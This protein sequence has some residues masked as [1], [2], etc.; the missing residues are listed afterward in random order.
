MSDLIP[1]GTYRGRVAVDEN[2]V[3]IAALSKAGTGTTQVAVLCEIVA[4]GPY[5]GRRD[6]W[7]GSLTDANGQ[8]MKAFARTLESLEIMGWEG[9]G[10][11]DLRG[12]EKNEFDIVV[13]H[14]TYNNVT[15]AKFSFVNRAGGNGLAITAAMEPQVAAAFSANLKGLILATRASRGNSGAA[16]AGNKAPAQ[17]PPAAPSR[18]PAPVRQPQTAQQAMG[19]RD[20]EIPF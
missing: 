9:T 13:Q 12:I 18:S 14:D 10:I 11:N 6:T 2:G 5:A 8:P 4:D 15:R 16:P 20:E 1:A 17:R 19:M 7:H 3:P